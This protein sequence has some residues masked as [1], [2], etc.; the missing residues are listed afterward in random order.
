MDKYTTD[1]DYFWNLIETNQN[2]AFAR[3][4]DGEVM[5][6]SGNMVDEHT[7]AGS[8]DKWT[9]PG[10]DSK[11]GT[12]L[13]DT[14]NHTESNYYYA[15]SGLSDNPND[16]N[17][18]RERIKNDE[19]N[20]TFVNLWINANYQRT[21]QKLVSLKRDAVLICNHSAGNKSFPFPIKMII[22]FPDNCVAFWEAHSEEY[23]KFLIQ[24][25]GEMENQLFFISCGPVSEII[26][27]RLYQY[28]PNNT[29]VDMGSSLD[30]L[31]HHQK[32][33][34]YMDPN[35]RYAREKSHF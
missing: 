2:F 12:E 1:F 8:V 18:L 11:V 33:R 14:L 4:A 26:I 30:E 10:G 28:N 5:L 3:Y 29:Y 20:L 34:P 16:H 7:Q 17:F 25:V 24:M 35:S 32:T 6:M 21:K 19:K 22:G 23:L 9:S 31:V 13:L 27:H 15:I